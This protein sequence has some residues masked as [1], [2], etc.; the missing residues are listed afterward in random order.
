MN[1][2]ETEA[3]LYEVQELFH[4]RP[5]HVCIST[6]VYPDPLYILLITVFAHR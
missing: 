1:D 4:E 3:V 5:H 6:F 2:E